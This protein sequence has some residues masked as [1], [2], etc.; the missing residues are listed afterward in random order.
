M[1]RT[2]ITSFQLLAKGYSF[3]LIFK[4]QIIGL[5]VFFI[6]QVHVIV[7]Y[8]GVDIEIVYTLVLHR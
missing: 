4:W 3:C 8:S 2:I 1:A 6:L 5:K 7:F